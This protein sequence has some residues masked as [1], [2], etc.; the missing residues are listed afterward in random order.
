MNKLDHIIKQMR[1]ESFFDMNIYM[2][3]SDN[4]TQETYALET[5]NCPQ[6]NGTV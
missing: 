1:Y 4:N 2:N 5:L 3:N 6:R